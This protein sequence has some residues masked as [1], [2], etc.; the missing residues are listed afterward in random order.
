MALHITRHITRRGVVGTAS[1]VLLV[2]TAGTAQA[3]PGPATASVNAH[4][5]K[6]TYQAS[7]GQSNKVVASVAW[8]DERTKLVY[9]IDDSVKVKI[10]RGCSYPIDDDHTSIRCEVEP[11]DSQ[12]PYGSLGMN[13]RDKNDSVEFHNNTT[14]VY[15]FNEFWLGDGKDTFDSSHSA[16]NDGSFVWGQ[17]G[18][19]QITTGSVAT[20]QGGNGADTI[21]TTGSYSDVDGGSGNDTILAG[22]GSQFLRGGAGDDVVRGGGGKDTLYGGPGNDKLYGEAGADSLYG[23]SG[24]DLLDG[25]PGTD[26]FSGGPGQD[27]LRP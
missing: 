17:N 27:T 16:T 25:G 22:V 5:W 9:L 15:Y 11:V 3:A 1:A 20:V 7:K 4:G 6:L 13:L 8:N 10:G 18:D 23:N 2:A 12:D 21:T 24:N 26:K 14:Q 19:D